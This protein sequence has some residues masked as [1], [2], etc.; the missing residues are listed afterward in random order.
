MYGGYP[1]EAN[2]SR[3]DY[4]LTYENL[5]DRDDFPWGAYHEVGHGHQESVWTM[6]FS[7]C[8]VNWFSI[9][10]SEVRIHTFHYI[11]IVLQK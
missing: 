1:M 10:M 2:P 6:G 11:N 3:V 9:A 5:H 4:Y 8:T 7:E